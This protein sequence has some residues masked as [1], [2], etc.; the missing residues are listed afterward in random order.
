MHVV[1]F[2]DSICRGCGAKS[3][4]SWVERLATAFPDIRVSNAG[5]DGDI[6]TEAL[7]RMARD[8][9]ALHPDIVYFQF[10]LNDCSWWCRQPGRPWVTPERYAANLREMAERSLRCGARAV[11]VGTS[12]LPACAG[13]DETTS[14]FAQ[15]NHSRRTALYNDI[16]RETLTGSPGV[17]IADLERALPVG[18]RI[19][20][21]DGVHLNETGNALY[22]DIVG[23]VLE[24][25]LQSSGVRR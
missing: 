4:E 1:F 19:V 14:D 16:V 6:T 7:R 10:G 15:M 20:L 24:A 3:G 8:V 2:G 18:E 11:L 23:R 25:V 9:E 5:V 22:A 12:H 21:P 13:G 17:H